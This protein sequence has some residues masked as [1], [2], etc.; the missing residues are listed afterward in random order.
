MHYP[1][2]AKVLWCLARRFVPAGLV[3]LVLLL[4]GMPP[5]LAAFGDCADPA[6]R[7]RFDDRLHDTPYDCIEVARVTVMTADGPRDIRL[8]R[9]RHGDWAT[10]P[11]VIAEFVRGLNAV[12]AAAAQL[13]NFRMF[14]V[15]VL[16][17]DQFSPPAESGEGFS[18]IAG[19]TGTHDDE[20][21]IGLYLLSA[22][23]TVRNAATGLVHEIF[24]CIQFATLDPS[25]L[26]TSGVGTGAGGDWWIEG[27]AEWFTAL[28]LP[29]T[30]LLS[31]RLARFDR[32]S[33]DTPLYEMAYEAVA[34]FLWLGADR[35]PAAILPLLQNMAT[36]SSAAAQQS[37]MR[38]M[39]DERGWLRFA[40]DYLDKAIAHPLGAPLAWA[41]ADGEL[42]RFDSTRT[43]TMRLAPFVLM[44]G[45][46]EYECGHWDNT[47]EPEPQHAARP[48]SGGAWGPVPASLVA[49]QDGPLRLRL[50]A[51]AG[52]PRPVT[53]SLTATLEAGCQPCQGTSGIDACV[54][55]V[56]EESGGG[57]VEWMRRQFPPGVSI[58]HARVEG[59]VTVLQADGKYFTAP[60]TADLTMLFESSEGVTRGDGSAVYQGSGRWSAEGGKLNMCQDAGT[61]SGHATMK[62]L[63]L[64]IP[65]QPPAGNITMDYSCSGNQMETRLPIPGVAD[66]I[67]TRYTRVSAL[68]E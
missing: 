53:L 60:R 2:F 33:P 59:G 67:T 65:P 16:L 55:G 5:A 20:C 14:P 35:G 49:K 48:E 36:S 17:M 40:Q 26:G 57:A 44:R 13:G 3:L 58:P 64:P 29:D 25:L 51:L 54:V 31:R 19:M 22:G 4:W 24:H 18:D 27:S 12:P 42:W 34:F 15:T 23:A 9:D 8:L 50:G 47:A 7:S 43:R 37:A 62:G 21:L 32:V 45:W 68:P 30:D 63:T 61:V 28:A 41:P 39:L 10:T 52:T 46:I 6:Y 11:E 1:C 38:A 66:P 56:W